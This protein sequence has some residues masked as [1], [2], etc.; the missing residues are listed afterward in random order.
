[1]S[2]F[3]DMFPKRLVWPGGQKDPE[4]ANLTLYQVRRIDA[5][6]TVRTTVWIGVFF[7]M[8]HLWRATTAHG[9]VVASWIALGAKV[10]VVVLGLLIFLT[11]IH[12]AEIVQKMHAT[13]GFRAH[14]FEQIAVAFVFV[15]WLGLLVFGM[16]TAKWLDVNFSSHDQFFRHL[17]RDVMQLPWLSIVCFMVAY[18]AF[19]RWKSAD[20]IDATPT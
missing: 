5:A 18:G 11:D 6:V 16:P 20:V 14:L 19:L 2:I 4:L 1:M 12:R 8:S 17:H 3:K 7:L 9:D 13:S 10:L 15:L